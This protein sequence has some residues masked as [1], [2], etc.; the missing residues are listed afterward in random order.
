MATP[1]KSTRCRTKP[2]K[3]WENERVLYTVEDKIS[4]IQYHNLNDDI[5]Q[6]A[7]SFCSRADF[8]KSCNTTGINIVRNKIFS[9]NAHRKKSTSKKY[10][11]KSSK[12]PGIKSPEFSTKGNYFF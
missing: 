8:K 10:F 1:R 11:S 3:H 2:L 9:N 7:Q 6:L 12:N 4:Y 5:S